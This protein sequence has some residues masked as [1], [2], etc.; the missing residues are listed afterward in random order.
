MYVHREASAL[1]HELS[2]ESDQFRFL[3]SV[4]F[5]DLKGSV[6]LIMTNIGYVDFNPPEPFISVTH[7]YHLDLILT[8]HILEPLSS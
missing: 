1:V 5:I 2:E 8:L 7:L 3:R 6:G 4:C